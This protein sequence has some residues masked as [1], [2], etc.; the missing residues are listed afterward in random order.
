MGDF[1]ELCDCVNRAND[2]AHAWHWSEA[3]RVRLGSKVRLC[4]CLAWHTTVG[5]DVAWLVGYA[6]V[7]G[8]VFRQ[9]WDVAVGLDVA[10]ASC[11]VR[12]EGGGAR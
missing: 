9:V 12:L 10:E 2:G 3:R 11:A 6:A 1:D 8:D 4:G 5:L 7:G